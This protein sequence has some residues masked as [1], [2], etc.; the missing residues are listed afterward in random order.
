MGGREDGAL[1]LPVERLLEFCEN[2]E[3][4][5]FLYDAGTIRR[6]AAQWKDAFSFCRYRLSAPV[7]ALPNPH[8]FRVLRECGVGAVCANEMELELA[9]RAGYDRGE[10]IYMMH[11]P[12]EPPRDVQLILDDPEQLQWLPKFLSD[13]VG[14]RFTPAEDVKLTP[15]TALRT[16]RGQFG[17]DQDQLIETALALVER[18]C[19]AVGLHAQFATARMERGFYRVQAEALFGAALQLHRWKIP[20]AYFDIGGGIGWSD[21]P[22]CAV[23]NICAIAED[24]G[25]LHAKML[26]PAGLGDVEIR[27]QPG[28]NLLAPGGILVSRVE[29]V[30]KKGSVFLNLD[31][32]SSDM[33]RHILYGSCYGIQLVPHDPADRDDSCSV[34]TVCGWLQEPGDKFASA[35]V[36]PQAKAGDLCVFRGVGA[37]AAAMGSP[38]GGNLSCAEYLLD[39]EIRLI[40]RRE[41]PAEYLATLIP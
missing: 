21:S 15:V 35:Q 28:R 17:R 39:G 38:Y 29:S 31:A 3:T 23:N 7:R 40:R 10:M 6:R 11:R 20:L 18:G 4:P 2:H 13:P 32:S 16:A 8:V 26:V 24:I 37:Y 19:P 1:F 22:N 41:R 33:M 14:L 27:S 30:R 12:E 36:L 9:R 34:C 25:E 5:F